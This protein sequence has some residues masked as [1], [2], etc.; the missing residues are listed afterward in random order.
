MRSQFSKQASLFLALA[1]LGLTATLARDGPSFSVK[2]PAVSAVD[3]SS[4]VDPSFC[5][6]A[7][8][9]SSFVRYA[10]SDDGIENIHSIQPGNEADLY[11]DTYT[12]E[13]G[14]ELHPPEYQGNQH[15]VR[16]SWLK[17]NRPEIPFI[18]NEQTDFYLY[19]LVIGVAR[20]NY[21]QITDAGYDLWLPVASGG[22]DAQPFVAGFIGSSDKTRVT[23]LSVS[24]SGGDAPANLAVYAAYEDSSAK[25]IAI[26]DLNFWN[27]TSSDFER[28]SVTL[29]LSVLQGVKSVKVYHL[30]SPQGAGAG[31]D[32]ITHGGS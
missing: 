31:A 3:A 7:F 14:I 20:I 26:T 21:Q 18:V 5:G 6:L 24:G 8:E 29:D 23:Q 16:I 28:P 17:K 10:P 32:S 2:A 25:W 13:D 15:K 11:S 19:G 4:K 12:G 22:L 1:S 27:M 9:Q 30:N